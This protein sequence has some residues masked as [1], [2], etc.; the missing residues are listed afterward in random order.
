MLID[1][2]IFDIVHVPNLSLGMERR[3]S[4]V[5]LAEEDSD[6]LGGKIRIAGA[7]WEVGGCL[8]RSC[9]A[10]SLGRRESWATNLDSFQ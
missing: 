9:R 3:G 5:A 8:G 1:I 7:V 10:D 6:V 4:D 2:F